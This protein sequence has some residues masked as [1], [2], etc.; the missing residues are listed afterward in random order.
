M[1]LFVNRKPAWRLAHPGKRPRARQFLTVFV[2]LGLSLAFPAGCS[3]LE[4]QRLG[5]RQYPPRP[6]D[7]PVKILLSKPERF[8]YV[9]GRIVIR[10]SSQARDFSYWKKQVARATREM[11]GDGAIYEGFRQKSHYGLQVYSRSGPPPRRDT[12]NQLVFMVY[13]YPKEIRLDK[14]KK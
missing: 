1:D 3:T 9:I 4:S 14:D 2:V 5:K 10:D 6:D 11:G 7:F 13:R 8:Y 12:M